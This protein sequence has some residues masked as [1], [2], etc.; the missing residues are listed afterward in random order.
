MKQI[1][2]DHAA[3]TPLRREVIEVMHQAMSQH[4]AIRLRPINLVVKQNQV[5]NKPEKQLLPSSVLTRQKLYLPQGG[6][7]RIT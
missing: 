4:L 6:Q 5:W 2:F 1:Y 7:K 3:T